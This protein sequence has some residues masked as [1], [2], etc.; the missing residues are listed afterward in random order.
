MSQT[1]ICV[2][3]FILVLLLLWDAGVG[4]SLSCQDLSCQHEKAQINFIKSGGINSNSSNFM[5]VNNTNTNDTI[6]GHNN[7]VKVWIDNLNN[8]KI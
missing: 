6:S 3:M 5:E 1:R 4:H 2:S 8:I 7:H